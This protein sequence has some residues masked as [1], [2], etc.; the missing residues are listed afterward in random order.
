MN[1]VAFGIDLGTSTSVV[2]Y[3]HNDR[4]VTI[5][6]P[7]SK[8]PIVPSIVALSA[9]DDTL[10]VGN[11]ALGKVDPA[12]VVRE[13]KR[14]M[15]TD[16]EFAVGA[17]ILTAPQVAALVL[18]KLKENAEQITGYKLTEAVITVPAYFDDLPRR[19]T[20]LAANL[21][22]IKTLR[23]ISEPVAAAT[24]YGLDKLSDQAM[25]VVFDF[26]GGT[27][28]VTIIEL[29]AGVLEVKATHG[30]K[31]LGGKDID[32][33][34]MRYVTDRANVP[35]P[36]AGTLYFELLKR[37]VEKAKKDLSVD[38]SSDIILDQCRDSA[39]GRTF[40]IDVQVTREQF[41]AVIQPIIDRAVDCVTVALDKAGVGRG[42]INRLLLV[43]GTCYTPKVRESIESMFALKAEAGLDPDLAVSQGAAISAGLKVGAIEAD[44]AV[45]VQD[46]ATYRIGTTILT[47][48][49][50]QRM[51]KFAE[52]MPANAK[53][54]FMRKQR[55]TLLNCTQDE[56]EIDVLIDPKG[57]AIFPEDA[58][59]TGAVGM[60]T[61]IPPSPTG[62]PWAIDVEI[63]YDENHIVQVEAKVVGLDKQLTL[64]LNQSEFVA[65]SL[66]S[67]ELHNTV[68]E[69]W[70]NAPQAA[71][72]A[73][74]IKRAESLASKHPASSEKIEAIVDD[75]KRA[76]AD[77][78]ENRIHDAR[79]RLAQFLESIAQ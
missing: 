46:A 41:N 72:N 57:T 13:A 65:N 69:L 15:G 49:G 28:D 14:Y 40:D 2:S 78:S 29:L 73:A 19:A 36:V 6:D 32:D 24:A 11:D 68:S 76:I 3:I 33:A 10:L 17:N 4:P 18:R 20:E 38:R 47:E 66:R 7:K 59:Q 56:C 34:F 62:E 22:D 12:T 71:R 16:H 43:G 52:L 45:I 31:E 42:E 23:L 67:I 27:L 35:F 61:D 53:V 77:D 21:A 48:V 5:N 75:L 44:D 79:V 60:L 25:L 70:N 54:P 30:N 74:L 64:K 37:E 39:T 8:S 1:R 51:A 55:Y 50:S 63:T 9:R 58:Q 26:G